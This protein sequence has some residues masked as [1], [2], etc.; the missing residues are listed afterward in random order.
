VV[1]V[2]AMKIP[3]AS[4][5]AGAVVVAATL[6][7]PACTQPQKGAEVAP[8]TAQPAWAANYADDLQGASKDLTDDR[9]QAHA[10][11]AQLGARAGDVKSPTDTNALLA[12]VKRADEAGR[13]AAY[14]QGA[15]EDRVVR[16]FWDDSR[17][18]I[19]G[20]AAGAAK[21]VVADA[22]CEKSPDP[23]GQVA[24]AVK[25]G[26]DRALEK[27]LREHN[28]AQ[29][30][31]ER[32]KVALGNGNASAVQKLADDVALASYLSNVA[33]QNDRNRVAALLQSRQAADDTLQ[34]AIADERAFQGDK[35]RTDAERKASDDRIA[36][37]QKSQQAIG[38]AVVS[39][40][41]ALKNVDDQIKQARSEHDAALRALED[42]IRQKT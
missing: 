13:S 27:R 23:S 4:S 12:I 6:A 34:R 38:G 2:A 3:S 11:D 39:A 35:G 7:L 32:Y 33:L 18:P 20:R 26:V 31:V 25:D 16:G 5:F 29:V 8:S 9:T 17:G 1:F 37:Y 41:V 40:D 10:I 14:V 15:E 30:L 21:T 19:V 22:K 36:Q 42:A 24:Y 28:D